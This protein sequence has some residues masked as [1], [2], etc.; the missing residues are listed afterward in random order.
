M[1]ILITGIHGFVD[2]NLVLALKNNHTI[3]GLYLIELYLVLLQSSLVLCLV[4]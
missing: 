2:S 3:Y 4:L 1:N